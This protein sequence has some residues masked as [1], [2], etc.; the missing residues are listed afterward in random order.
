[1]LT[2]WHS[3]DEYN[4]QEKDHKRIEELETVVKNL[5]ANYSKNQ[6]E[7][8]IRIGELETAVKNLKANYDEVCEV[9]SKWYSKL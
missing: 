8:H 7:D 5:K 4:N 2:A 6:E 1:V 9:Y 3:D